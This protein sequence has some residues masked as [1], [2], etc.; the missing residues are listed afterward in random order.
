MVMHMARDLGDRRRGG[1]GFA[2]PLKPLT[3]ALLVHVWPI[4]VFLTLQKQVT[5]DQ[6]SE[7]G[8]RT[9]QEERK[10][11]RNKLSCPATFQLPCCIAQQCRGVL[12]GKD[13]LPIRSL[14]CLLGAWQGRD[15]EVDRG[16]KA[17]DKNSADAGFCSGGVPVLV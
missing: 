8:L 1:V 6:P 2:D 5:N 7:V 9:Q 17:T 13:R 14:A 16:P 10:S 11:A 4:E 3:N 15:V 12:D